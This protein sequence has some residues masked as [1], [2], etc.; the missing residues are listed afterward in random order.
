[1]TATSMVHD[2]N[3]DQLLV[4]VYSA[5]GYR[6]DAVVSSIYS[7][8]LSDQINDEQADELH[9]AANHRRKVLRVRRKL[10]AT[11]VTLPRPAPEQALANR[12]TWAF[13]GALPPSLRSRF[14]AGENAV[15][16]VIRAEVR[17]H[18]TCTL[19][20]AQIARAAGLRSTTV[21]KR[22]MREARRLGLILVRLRP[23]Q[24]GRNK[25]NIVTITSRA[26]L[27]WNERAEW[28]HERAYDSESSLNQDTARKL[29][30][31]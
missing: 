9:T 5:P 15:A 16:A 12:R 23:V 27:R 6:I 28:G 13:S 30:S 1:M 4:A 7:A 2:L 29:R 24:G 17:R 26:W 18:G 19:S 22:F 25:T 31:A 20:N 10:C 3:R 11:K 21:V 14:T 8:Q